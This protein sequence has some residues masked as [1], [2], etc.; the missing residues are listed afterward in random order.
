[1]G[2]CSPPIR[3]CICVL[4][5]WGAF[6][7]LERSGSFYDQCCWYVNSN[8]PPLSLC[9]KNNHFLFLFALIFLSLKSLTWVLS[10]LFFFVH[11]FVV[12]FIADCNGIARRCGYHPFDNVIAVGFKDGSAC[13]SYPFLWILLSLYSDLILSVSLPS[14]SSFSDLLSFLLCLLCLHFMCGFVCASIA[15]C[16]IRCWF[17]DG[18]IPHPKTQARNLSDQVLPRR[19]HARCGIAR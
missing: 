19:Q 14:P 8:F 15:D 12:F 13:F 16:F 11:F 18:N 3:W 5:G 9:M 2:Y 17:D 1:M 7:S 10:F 4:F 6:E